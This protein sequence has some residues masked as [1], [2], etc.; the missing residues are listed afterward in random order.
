LSAAKKAKLRNNPSRVRFAEGVV[1]NGTTLPLV[2]LYD[3][4]DDD[5]I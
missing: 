2:F 1:I 4:D 3:D 5:D